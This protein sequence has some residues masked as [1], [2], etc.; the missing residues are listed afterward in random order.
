MFKVYMA[1]I[2][3]SFVG[4]VVGYLP[5]Y[6]TR[7]HVL[8]P[9]SVPVL[10]TFPPLCIF[11]ITCIFV[12][13][14]KRHFSILTLSEVWMYER[15]KKK[16]LTWSRLNSIQYETIYVCGTYGGRPWLCCRTPWL[17]FKELFTLLL[18]LT[19]MTES[20]FCWRISRVVWWLDYFLVLHISIIVL[21]SHFVVW[22]CIYNW[23]PFSS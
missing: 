22:P 15:Q 14:N 11:H 1:C 8:P 12:C 5:H 13:E 20:H 23:M 6:S 16:N 17:T 2:F 4:S 21:L 18:I 10:W 3:F 7:G 19:N 9:M